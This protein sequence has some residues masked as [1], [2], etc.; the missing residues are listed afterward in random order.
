MISAPDDF[1]SR[2]RALLELQGTA[3]SDGDLSS[4]ADRYA[5]CGGKGSWDVR[6]YARPSGWG[7]RE[8]RVVRGPGVQEVY[9]S[10][11]PARAAAVRAALNELEALD[12][13]D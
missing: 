6:T 4:I 13:R 11:E 10:P 5:R 8:Y 3:L 9:T 7:A 12:G 2:V 1:R